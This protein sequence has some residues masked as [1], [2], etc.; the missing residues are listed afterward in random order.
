MN[1]SVIRW[2][3]VSIAVFSVSGC[4]A[5]ATHTPQT[6]QTRSTLPTDSPTSISNKDT[7]GATDDT[8]VVTKSSPQ[9]NTSTAETISDIDSTGDTPPTANTDIA[10]ETTDNTQSNTDTAPP[11][12]A[13]EAHAL[14]ETEIVRQTRSE[15][16]LPEQNKFYDRENPAYPVLQK[17]NQ[18]MTGFPLD[19]RGGIDWMSVLREGLITPRASINSDGDLQRRTDEIIMKQTLNMPYVLFP[20]ESHTEWL[21]CENCHPKPFVATAG[22]NNFTMNDMYQG[23]FC[24]MCHDRVAFETFACERCH[25]VLHAGSPTKWW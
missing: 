8:P 24:G 22:A 15:E 25:S 2:V 6:E 10:P 12:S 21:A 23:K 13:S 14:Q 1:T 9:D 11:A 17:A 7:G 19:T 16:V 4:Q 20:H 18:A 3:V 5:P